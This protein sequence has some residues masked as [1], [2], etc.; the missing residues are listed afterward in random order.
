[1]LVIGLGRSGRASCAVLR[2]RGATVYAVD[3]QDHHNLREAIEEITDAGASFVEQ[4]ALEDILPGWT[5]PSFRPA[6]R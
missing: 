5:S 6:S 2:A 4:D 3:E 1:M